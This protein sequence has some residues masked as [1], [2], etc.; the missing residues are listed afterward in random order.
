MNSQ[1]APCDIDYMRLALDLARKAAQNGDVPVGALVV[2]NGQIVGQGYNR[3]EA[4]Q[5][6][7]CHAEITAIREA[8]R[9]TGSWRLEHSTL[10]VTLEPCLMCAG[11]IIQSRI[12]RVVYGAPDPKTGMAGSVSNVFTLPSNHHVVL[13]AGLLTDE[14]GALLRQFFRQR[15][16]RNKTIGTRGERRRIKQKS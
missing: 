11:A 13:E 2:Q 6:A 15:R 12:G 8:C 16:L 9:L 4:E 14:C 1:F 5:D 10:Y 3:R 7:T